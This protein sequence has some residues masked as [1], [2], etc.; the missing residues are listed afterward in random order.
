MP[1]ADAFVSNNA[2]VKTIRADTRPSKDL[3]GVDVKSLDIVKFCKLHAALSGRTFEEVLPE[4][5][6]EVHAVSDD[7]PWVYAFPKSL[8]SALATLR[9]AERALVA[10]Q[11]AQSREFALDGIDASKVAAIF[12]ELVKLAGLSEQRDER[13][14]LWNSL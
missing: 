12:E 2:T 13:L 7:G 9:D 6:P 5:L 14:F 4:F 1:L 10:K 8:Q 11:W 3:G